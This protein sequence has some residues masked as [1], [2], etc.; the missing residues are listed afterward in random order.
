[1]P[2]S[3]QLQGMFIRNLTDSS[4]H[5]RVRARRRAVTM[6]DVFRWFGWFCLRRS[7][8]RGGTQRNH[9]DDQN[10]EVEQSCAFPASHLHED[11]SDYESRASHFSYRSFVLLS[12]V[13]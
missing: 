8:S 13:R 5:E 11:E 9:D 2:V 6:H 3:H 12:Q 4:L 7:L 10:S 1:M